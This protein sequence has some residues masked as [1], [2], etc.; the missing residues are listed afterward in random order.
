MMIAWLVACTTQ[1]FEA[2]GGGVASFTLVPD[3]STEVAVEVAGLDRDQLRDLVRGEA[4]FASVPGFVGGWQEPHAVFFRAYGVEGLAVCGAPL[5][6]AEIEVQTESVYLYFDDGTG[7]AG[8]VD[9][10][11]D[12]V[13][14]LAEIGPV[15]ETSF[16][17]RFQCPGAPDTPGTLAVQWAFD[18]DTTVQHVRREWDFGPPVAE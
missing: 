10:V 6:V 16:P 3:G 1:R 7:T 9:P 5:A 13:P 15:G 17:V 14:I 18:P 11:L 12:A 4:D 8:L 2:T